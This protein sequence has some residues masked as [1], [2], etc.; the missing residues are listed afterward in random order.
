MPEIPPDKL[1]QLIEKSGVGRRA[2]K[3]LREANEK[4]ED[5]KQAS[6]RR[7]FGHGSPAERRKPLVTF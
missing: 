2:A 4:R 1:E 3:M 6:R 7:R 5:T